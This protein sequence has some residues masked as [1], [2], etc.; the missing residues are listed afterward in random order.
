[1]QC[2]VLY[3]ARVALRSIDWQRDG[4]NDSIQKIIFFYHDQGYSSRKIAVFMEQGLK[5]SAQ[6]IAKFLIVQLY[7]LLA[8][9]C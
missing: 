1:M 5:G 9:C 8:S 2:R 3:S 4:L 7:S 6:D